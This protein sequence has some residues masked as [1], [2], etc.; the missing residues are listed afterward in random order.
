MKIQSVSMV[1]TQGRFR[2]LKKIVNPNFWSL[3]MA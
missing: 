3:E 2:P 1:T